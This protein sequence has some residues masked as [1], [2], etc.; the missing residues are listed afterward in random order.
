MNTE[1][2]H[3]TFS[4]KRSSVVDVHG[5]CRSKAV[6][7]SIIS[8]HQTTCLTQRLNSRKGNDHEVMTLKKLHI[9]S[10]GINLPYHL[11]RTITEIA[12]EEMRA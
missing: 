11:G 8:H 5:A 6:F 3:Y 7:A 4:H 10:Q 2:L 12:V 1:C 9:V